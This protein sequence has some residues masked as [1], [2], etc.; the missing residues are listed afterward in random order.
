[1]SSGF[2]LQPRPLPKRGRDG[3]GDDLR[4][5]DGFVR[6]RPGGDR[7][8]PLQPLPEQF[9]GGRGRGGLR[10]AGGAGALAAR[11]ELAR[12]RL[13]HDDR[14]SAG[15]PSTL[16]DAIATRQR[17]R[18]KSVPGA[19]LRRYD[20][21]NAARNLRAELATGTPARQAGGRPARSLRTA[22]PRSRVASETA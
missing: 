7:R 15:T 16:T 9:F 8:I 10:R 2:R 11:P 20:P 17:S 5:F 12:V 13:G 3:D 21:P 6:A 14:S 18:A 22:N 1:E 19:R 4:C